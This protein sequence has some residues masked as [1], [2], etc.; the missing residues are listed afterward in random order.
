MR[1][2]KCVN[3][4]VYLDAGALCFDC[5]RMIVVTVIAEL[6]VAAVIWGTRG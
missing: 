2:R 5:V 6:I 3:C 1:T 4:R